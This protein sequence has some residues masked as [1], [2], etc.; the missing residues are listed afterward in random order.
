MLYEIWFIVPGYDDIRL[1][2]NESFVEIHERT[3]TLNYMNYM[4][5]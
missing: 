2:K 3:D 5:V 4:F 1:F